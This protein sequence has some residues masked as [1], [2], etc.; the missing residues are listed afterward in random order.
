MTDLSV[1]QKGPVP[2][3]VVSVRLSVLVLSTSTYHVTIHKVASLVVPVSGPYKILVHCRYGWDDPCLPPPTSPVG[4][5]SLRLERRNPTPPRYQASF[6]HCTSATDTT[7]PTL[8]DLPVGSKP[9]HLLF[10]PHQVITLTLS[11]PVY[12][13]RGARRPSHQHP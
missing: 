10:P 5:L 13:Y 1:L 2:Y 9:R 8:T 4:P 7:S 3:E 11:P 6:P 12:P